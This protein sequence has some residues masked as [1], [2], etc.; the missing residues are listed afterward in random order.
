M[1]IYSVVSNPQDCSKSFA[2]YFPDI[3]VQSDT[4]S[5]F[6]GSIQ[7]YAAITARSNDVF[8]YNENVSII[9]KNVCKFRINAIGNIPFRQITR[10][11]KELHSQSADI[12]NISLVVRHYPHE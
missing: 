11:T 3:P 5:T 2:L 1:F 7:P 12:S 8:L 4:I 9:Y 10:Y 6:L